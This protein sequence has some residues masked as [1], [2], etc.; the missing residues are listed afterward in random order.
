MLPDDVVNGQLGVLI[1]Y[2][3]LGQHHH[4]ERLATALG[5]TDHTP[6]AL[7]ARD[8]SET[9]PALLDGEVLLVVG[10]L[11]LT[12]VVDREVEREVEQPLGTAQGVEVAVL[13]GDLKRF[14][15]AVRKEGTHVVPA[16]G[17]ER[18]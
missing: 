10:N 2:D 17:E 12:G 6:R 8:G 3:G 18:I 1:I 14:L 5:M 16:L 15:A 7:P 11:L 9:A 4:S 13:L